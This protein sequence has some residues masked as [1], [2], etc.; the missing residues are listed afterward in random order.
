MQG[1]CRNFKD[2]LLAA[3]TR[4]QRREEGVD[5]Y[6]ETSGSRLDRTHDGLD[7]RNVQEEMPR[8]P[9]SFLV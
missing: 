2:A 6:G 5:G 9:P 3:C 7:A 1:D 4:C 8:K